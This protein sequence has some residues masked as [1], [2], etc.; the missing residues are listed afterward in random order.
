MLV[1]VEVL[2]IL[3]EDSTERERSELVG[4]LCSGL[5]EETVLDCNCAGGDQGDDEEPQRVTITIVATLLRILF[6]ES[7]NTLG[8]KKRPI[9]RRP[10][11]SSE[12]TYRKRYRKRGRPYR[13][14]YRVSY[15]C[16][17]MEENDILAA[18]IVANTYFLQLSLLIL[19]M[20]MKR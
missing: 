17:P 14:L 12:V 1:L 15:H 19:P 8:Y 5:S 7:S 6:T 20:R 11:L 16:E 9:N 10:R 2:N 3:S 13:S 18:A 4:E